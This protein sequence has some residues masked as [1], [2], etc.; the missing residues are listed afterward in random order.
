MAV[1]CDLRQVCEGDHV[2]DRAAVDQRRSKPDSQAGDRE[3]FN[4]G[5]E[6]DCCQAEVKDG[7]SPA[8]ADIGIGVVEGRTEISDVAAD[9]LAFQPMRRIKVSSS[10]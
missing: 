10:S 2:A 6:R 3:A 5:I 7:P 1:H 9:C 4:G 8:A